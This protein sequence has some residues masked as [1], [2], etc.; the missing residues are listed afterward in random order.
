M[1]TGKS[2]ETIASTL[3]VFQIACEWSQVSFF[4]MVMLTI[5]QYLF[6]A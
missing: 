2:F 1:A 6:K 5:I 4:E 3:H